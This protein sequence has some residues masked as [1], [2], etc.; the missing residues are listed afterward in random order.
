M[1]WAKAGESAT[2]VIPMRIA[3]ISRRLF[4]PRH[5]R[6][7]LASEKRRL[8]NSVYS[9]TPPCVLTYSHRENSV[10]SDTTKGYLRCSLADEIKGNLN[11]I[12]S[13]YTGF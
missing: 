13:A 5:A 1:I 11:C 8:Q 6:D 7:L 10:E 12:V 9:Q 3:V 4:L 2:S